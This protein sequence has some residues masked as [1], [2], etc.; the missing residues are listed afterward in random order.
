[1]YPTKWKVVSYINLEP[2]RDLWKQTKDHQKII[3]EH[4]EKLKNDTCYYLTDC[5]AFQQYVKSKIHYVDNL[6][7]LIAEYLVDSN[8]PKRSRTKRGVLNFVGDIAKIL[9]GTLSQSDAEKYNNHISEI[10][11]EQLE[12]LHILKDE[13]TVIKSTLSAVN[14]TIQRVNKNE[15]LL[16]DSLK[17]LANYTVDKIFTL[18]KEIEKVNIINEQIRIIYRGLEECQHSFEIL[19]DAFVHAKQGTLQPQLITIEKIKNIIDAQKL[20]AGLDFPD[21]P[22]FDLQKLI[23]PHTYSYNQYLVYVLEIPLLSSTNYQLYKVLPFPVRQDRNYVF[24]SSNK[25]YIFCDSVRQHYG[26][27][28]MSELAGCFRP[29]E[30]QY[31]CQENF[32]IYTYVPGVDCEATLLHPSTTQ[33]PKNCDTRITSLDKTFWIPLYLSNEW[34]FIAPKQDKITVLCG[35]RSTHLNIEKEGKLA[36]KQNCKAYSSY[37]TLYAMTTLSTNNTSDFMPS[38]SI[39]FDCC[40]NIEK[41]LDVDKILT[42]VPLVNLMSSADDLRVASIRAEQLSKMIKEQEEKDFSKWYIHAT[43]WS[44]IVGTIIFITLSCCCCFCCCK[45]CR[46]FTFWLWDK[47]IPKNCWKDTSD[48]FCVSIHNY[49]SHEQVVYNKTPQSE[50]DSPAATIRS[51]PPVTSQPLLSISSSKSVD[52]VENE[53]VS[54]RTRSKTKAFR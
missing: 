10:E 50:K 41:S 30:L 34:L 25:E 27:L 13:T 20:P 8:E 26:K 12:F 1:M 33:M 28:S 21:F 35:E 32:P 29:N 44:S 9:F 15:Q 37:V 22:L 51:L 47:S 7:N 6:K 45:R 38:V 4:S 18:E 5:G 48:R 19:I 31:V 3:A 46:N 54:Q 42:N 53:R 11:K 52:D 36:L 17:K 39:D 49:A 24:I 23:V 43:A 14:L 2:T 16:K 40:F